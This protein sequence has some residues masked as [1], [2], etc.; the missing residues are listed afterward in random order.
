MISTGKNNGL[1][2]GVHVRKVVPMTCCGMSYWH[3]VMTIDSHDDP[4]DTVHP[5]DAHTKK[6]QPPKMDQDQN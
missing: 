2:F 4:D 3:T 6:A 1:L 5:Y